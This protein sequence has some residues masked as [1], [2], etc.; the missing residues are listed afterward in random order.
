M[1]GPVGHGKG[2]GFYSE[3]NVKPLEAINLRVNAYKTISTV[4]GTYT[5]MKKNLVP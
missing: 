3:S 4:S 1:L 2:F 5:V